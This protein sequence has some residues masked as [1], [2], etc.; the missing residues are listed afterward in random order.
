V[1]PSA[2]SLPTTRHGVGVESLLGDR[3]FENR[4]LTLLFKARWSRDEAEAF[5]ATLDAV[6]EK[7]EALLPEGVV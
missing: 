2:L 3:E 4:I 7:L 5:R 6:I 1:S